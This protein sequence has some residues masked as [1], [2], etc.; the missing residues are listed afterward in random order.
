M[1]LP[2]WL[3]AIMN[4]SVVLFRLIAMSMVCLA[5]PPLLCRYVGPA[6]GA[7]GALGAAAFWYSQYRFPARKERSGPYFWFVAGGYGV[8]AITLVV[9]LGRLRG[10]SLL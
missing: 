1:P 6:I 10:V 5:A 9:C 4:N 7:L 3:P 2:V 8:I